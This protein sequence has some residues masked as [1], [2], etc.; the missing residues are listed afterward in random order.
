MLRGEARGFQETIGM[1]Q[2]TFA[3]VVAGAAT[4][5]GNPASAQQPSEPSGVVKAESADTNRGP[6]IRFLEGTDVFWSAAQKD[7]R[8]TEVRYFPNKLEA[9]IFPHLI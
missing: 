6:I 8:D 4:V 7:K 2:P 3:C 1:R 9:N 5:C